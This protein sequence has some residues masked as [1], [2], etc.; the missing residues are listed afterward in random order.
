VQARI[1]TAVLG[2]P[3]IIIFIQAGGVPFFFLIL[4]LS[5]LGLRE[6]YCLAHIP[7]ELRIWGYTAGALLLWALWR[8]PD[9]LGGMAAFLLLSLL[10]T[11]L[12]AFPRF[13]FEQAGSAL[14]GVL[15]IPFLFSYL[16][17]LH[18]LPGGR[19]YTLLT[20]ILTWVSDSVAFLVGTRWGRHRLAARLS[21]KKTWEG[22]VAGWF[23]CVLVM[24]FVHSWFGLGIWQAMAIGT[25]VG[26]AAEVGDLVESALKRQAQVKDSGNILPGHGGILDRFDALLFVA[27]VMY[28]SRFWLWH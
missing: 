18:G 27:P 21:P 16:L 3:A 6:Y 11:I 13:T 15:Y 12:G 10:V 26:L 23:G 14:L 7:Q 5:L 4:T 22:A 17:R 28:A 9:Y 2:V 24:F 25:V 8:Q 1:L 19:E 20:F